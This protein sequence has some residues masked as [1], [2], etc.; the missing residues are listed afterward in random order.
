[1]ARKIYHFLQAHVGSLQLL[2]LALFF[3]LPL[4]NKSLYILSQDNL[5]MI[6]SFEFGVLVLGFLYMGFLLIPL[7]L[8]PLKWAGRT[9]FIF[10]IVIAIPMTNYYGESYGLYGYL[11]FSWLLFANYSRVFLF[12]GES[13]NRAI[14]AGET[15]VRT[16]TYLLMFMIV[17]AI[18][19]MPTYVDRW[20]GDKVLYFGLFYFGVMAWWEW[21]QSFP[22]FARWAYGMLTRSPSPKMPG[23]KIRY[24]KGKIKALVESHSIQ[25][26]WIGFFLVGLL[27]SAFGLA[28][29]VITFQIDEPWWVEA[30]VWLL[31]FP[32]FLIGLMILWASLVLLFKA[33]KHGPPLVEIQTDDLKKRK[34][35]ATGYIPRYDEKA[36][37]KN[38]TA[39][40]I[41]YRAQAARSVDEINRVEVLTE[42]ELNEG[43]VAAEFIGKRIT[44]SIETTLPPAPED[45]L[46]KRDFHII[47]HLEIRMIY[48]ESDQVEHVTFP[49]PLNTI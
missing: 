25:R 48:E 33:V 23:S 6:L 32:V 18:L 49:L 21:R 17:S 27:C 22:R 2:L 38:V 26:Q 7:A 43:K 41:C 11:S 20:T 4:L 34:L 28:F 44:F 19:D 45:Y 5:D 1:M 13:V 24:H 3:G 46:I 8:V 35:Y 42:K 15:G 9:C 14:L 12:A 30:F 47:W 16:L 37:R 31:A 36:K 29:L 10:A 40:I 39:K